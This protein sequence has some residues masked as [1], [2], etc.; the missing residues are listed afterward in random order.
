[1]ASS[2]FDI[3]SFLRPEDDALSEREIWLVQVYRFLSVVGG[4]LIPV[5][6][7][8]YQILPAEYVD[9]WSARITMAGLFSVLIVGSYFSAWMRRHYVSLMW[10]CLYLLVA[11]VSALA[12]LNQVSGDY[13]VALLFVF[14]V[15]GVCIG[16]GAQR[17]APLVWFEGCALLLAA[18]IYVVVSDP[19]TSSFALVGCMATLSIVLYVVFQGCPCGGDSRP[20]ARTPRLILSLW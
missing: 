11:W 17:I 9:P 14:C 18:S 1:M 10:G 8:L 16:I 4:T 3:L 5:F 15:V 19:A 6:G 20:R 2:L 12:A 7:V 13:A